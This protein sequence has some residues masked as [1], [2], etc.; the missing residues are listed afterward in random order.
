MAAAA[1]A[2]AAS[3]VVGQK[4][5]RPELEP[6]K[7]EPA[8]EDCGYRPSTHEVRYDKISSI[9]IDGVVRG[10]CYECEIMHCPL[11]PAESVRHTVDIYARRMIDGLCSELVSLPGNDAYDFLSGAETWTLVPG[12]DWTIVWGDAAPQTFSELDEDARD[13]A[14]GLCHT[15]AN[16]EWT[17][18]LRGG[19]S[20]EEKACC[21]SSRCRPN[22]A[23]RELIA[24]E[25]DAVTQAAFA[26]SDE[27]LGSI[28]VPVQK[29]PTPQKEA[30]W[31]V[32]KTFS[33]RIRARAQAHRHAWMSGLVPTMDQVSAAVD[34]MR[35]MPRELA[36]IVAHYTTVV[37]SNGPPVE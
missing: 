35:L 27:P 22:A 8:C 36:R 2:A 5:P 15:D 21:F 37:V 29:Q 23:M 33:E 18:Q 17:L 1:A 16:T 14:H 31:Q 34:V 20:L 6:D 10:L 25:A 4:R 19:A 3:P 28:P 9:N 24:R 12:F 26:M 11:V 7:E 32:R 13:W 30:A